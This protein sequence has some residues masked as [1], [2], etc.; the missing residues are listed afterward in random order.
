MLSLAGLA[1]MACV[2]GA[3]GGYAWPLDL[4]QSLTSS[5]GEYRARKF[6]AG[7][8]LR[9]GDPGKEVHAAD[10]GFVSR[11]RS[12]PWG[13][14]KA[15]YI[16]LKDGNV[17]V[18]GHLSDFYPPLR[19]YVHKAQHAAHSYSVEL[20]PGPDEFPVKRGQVVAK[21][22]ETGAGPPHLHYEIRDPQ[23]RPL[24]PRLLGVTW[25]DTT[26]PVIHKV[27]VVPATPDDRVNG[28][29]LPVTLS[30][31]AV[32]GVYRTEPVRVQGRVGFGVDV[33]DP[34]NENS[35]QL[36]VHILRTSMDENELFRI[37]HDRLSYDTIGN[38]A[39]AY[40]PF[41]LDKGRFLLQWR[42]PGN[43]CDIFQPSPSD[44]WYTV[45][46]THADARI[47]A[48]D[49]LL[50][51]VVV[52]VPLEPGAPDTPPAP[53]SAGGGHGVMRVDCF[54]IWLVVTA[55]F[56]APEPEL[57]ALRIDGASESEQRPFFRVNATTFRAGFLP[58]DATREV[59][60]RTAH[61]RMAPVEQ[62]IDVFV[63]GAADTSVTR[64]TVTARVHKNS[65]YGNLFLT[66]YATP[67]PDAPAGLV[68]L[69]TSYRLWPDDSPIDTPVEVS[70]P[71]PAGA[72]KADRLRVY[73]NT[74]DGWEVQ[75]TKRAGDQLTISMRRFGTY[76]VME[77]RQAPAI[78]LVA[79][80]NPADLDS[81]R[82]PLNIKVTDSGSGVA[83]VSATC[84]RQWLLM[85]YDP[86]RDLAE[87]ARDEEIAPG[88]HTVVFKAV[89]RVG[90][91]ATLKHEL[92][93]IPPESP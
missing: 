53:D 2:G 44:G 24:N 60:V 58:R 26:P 5:F 43:V 61:P 32:D 16:T 21:S 51:K 46:S 42:W 17:V 86:E 27:L 25:P 72:Q 36:G 29:I 76:A 9:T 11:V 12:G 54:G 57:P 49:F 89:D 90:N 82:P 45:P 14:G 78:S 75:D 62:H 56:S 28:D 73:R 20:T 92:R 50:N 8:D 64:N 48:V 35:N 38:G 70:F 71:A 37:V 69:G 22:G 39:V 87:W 81:A 47:E 13:Y 55:E 85:E 93:K 83:E 3:N 33:I 80:V 77:D 63:R 41:V 67:R 1:L 4:P 59:T 19:D 34:A 7:I 68:P 23:E 91:A 88:P 18:Y 10:D 31:R 15:V 6:H 74:S 84:D 79:P 65:P 40:H 30:A 52:T 66:V